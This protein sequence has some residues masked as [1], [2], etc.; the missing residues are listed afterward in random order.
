[1]RGFSFFFSG[2]CDG[3][4]LL[5]YDAASL[6]NRIPTFRDHCLV[7][8]CSNLE[9]SGTDYSVTRRHNPE[10]WK[11]KNG[12]HYMFYFHITGFLLINW[13]TKGFKS[14]A[15]RLLGLWVRILPGAWIFVSCECCV[16]SG[17]GLCNGLITHAEESYRV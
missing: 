13:S 7:S 16:L 12:I 11:P 4:I 3:S 17:R 1:M 6:D 14:T 15:A 8:L 9:T 10:E 2:V 5:G